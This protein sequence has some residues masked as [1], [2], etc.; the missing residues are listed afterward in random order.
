MP[1][2]MPCRDCGTPTETWKLRRQVNRCATCHVIRISKLILADH[3]R[4][5]AIRQAERN[6][7]KLRPVYVELKGKDGKQIGRTYFQMRDS[8]KDFHRFYELEY[9]RLMRESF[10]FTTENFG[11][12]RARRMYTCKACYALQRNDESA[13]CAKHGCIPSEATYY[14]RLALD[15]QG[16]E[17]DR[18]MKKPAR[19]ASDFEYDG[20]VPNDEPRQYVRT[21]PEDMRGKKH[22]PRDLSVS[23]VWATRGEKVVREDVHDDTSELPVYVKTKRVIWK[24]VQ[25]TQPV[26]NNDIDWT[27]SPR[28]R[29]G[30]CKPRRHTCNPPEH[31]RIRN[32]IV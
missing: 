2:E 15:V 4:D 5:Y 11:E 30:R 16:M 9:A 32:Y 21:A 17:R 22:N 10:K 12:I 24:Q 6:L 3:C 19:I 31:M 20:A 7:A 14:W 23:Y 28:L 13:Y 18:Y 29:V 25:R 1:R 26:G 8:A 27:T